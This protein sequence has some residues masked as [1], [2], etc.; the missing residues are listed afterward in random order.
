MKATGIVRK[1]ENSGMIGI[2]KPIRE[3][4]DIS[5]GDM[6]E[7]FTDGDNIILQKIS[8]DSNPADELRKIANKYADEIPSGLAEQITNIAQYLEHKSA[9]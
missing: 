4:F 9:E 1:V 2:P 8:Y 3:Q 6:I 7:F 5:T